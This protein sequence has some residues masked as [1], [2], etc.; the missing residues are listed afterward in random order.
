MA[1]VKKTDFTGLSS[2]RLFSIRSELERELVMHYLWWVERALVRRGALLIAMAL[3]KARSAF[4]F[5]S[6]FSLG[7]L[8]RGIAN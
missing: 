2:F 6:P 7:I 4:P 5:G 8:S 3:G 1:G